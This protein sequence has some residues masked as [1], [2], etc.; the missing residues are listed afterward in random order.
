MQYAGTAWL[1][2]VGVC[3][4]YLSQSSCSNNTLLADPVTDLYLLAELFLLTQPSFS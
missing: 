3:L 1:R 4:L 2:N